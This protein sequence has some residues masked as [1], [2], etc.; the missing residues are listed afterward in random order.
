MCDPGPPTVHPGPQSAPLLVSVSWLKNN[1]KTPGIKILDGTWHAPAWNRDAEAEYLSQHIEGAEKFN[2]DEVVDKT[3]SLPYT[4]PP[5]EQFDAYVGGKL[6]ISNDDHVIIYDNYSPLGM[7]SAPRVWYTFKLYGHDKV[8]VL[9]GGFP[10][11]LEEGGPVGSGKIMVKRQPVSYKGVYTPE[12]IITYE[13]YYDAYYSKSAKL[14]DARP[15]GRFNGTAPEPN[16]KFHSGH[17]KGSS[18]LLWFNF[19]D[20]KTKTVKKPEEIV[21]VFADV[22]V[23]IYEDNCIGSC[24]SG[25]F[26]TWIAFSARLLNRNIPIYTGSW[27]EWYQR[28]PDDS[29]VLGI[30]GE[31]LRQ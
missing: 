24:G 29:K 27:T 16:P 9:D 4:L 20:Q 21:K 14:L 23:N 3:S 25:V 2:V 30:K 1:L 17:V 12:V 22:G 26:S 10:K 28:G 18:N 19:I 7:S 11:W 8:S 13:Q 15:A 6:G 5:V 31:D